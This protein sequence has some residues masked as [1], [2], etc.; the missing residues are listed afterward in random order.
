MT[1]NLARAPHEEASSNASAA[2]DEAAVHALDDDFWEVEGDVSL[3]HALSQMTIP[4]PS[5]PGSSQAALPHK[6]APTAPAQKTTE[7]EKMW[8]GYV[9]RD[10]RKKQDQA[11][12]NP[13]D[14]V[15]VERGSMG[16]QQQQQRGLSNRPLSGRP[17]ARSVT[18]ESLHQTRQGVSAVPFKP[19]MAPVKSSQTPP[20]A[21]QV[22]PAQNT[23]T[24]RLATSTSAGNVKS[25]SSSNGASHRPFTKANSEN[26]LRKPFKLPTV[27]NQQK[28]LA[29]REKQKSAKGVVSQPAPYQG[30]DLDDIDWGDDSFS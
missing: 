26:T 25:L 9:P 10:R 8:T 3:E 16:E 6:A 5:Q 13:V 14:A 4:P 20:D 15:A 7:R 28:N 23:S 27:Q 1:S 30:D 17:L 2:G 11:A 19:Q 12:E 29:A 21:V 22:I 24:G 18:S